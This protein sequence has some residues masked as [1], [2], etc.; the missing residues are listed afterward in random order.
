MKKMIFMI[1]LIFL[2]VGLY[3]Q[4]WTIQGGP[5]NDTEFTV[6]TSEQFQRIIQAQGTV[7]RTVMVEYLDYLVFM[8][9]LRSVPV[10]NGTIPIFNGYFYLTSRSIPKNDT[11]RYF[12]QITSAFVMY[13]NTRTNSIMSVRFMNIDGIPNALSLRR[14]WNEYVRQYNRLIRL[15]NGE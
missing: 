8:N 4:S 11:G 13:G 5:S 3:P 12:S 9:A 10:I 6:I 1:V 14:D 15:V 7:A 2:G